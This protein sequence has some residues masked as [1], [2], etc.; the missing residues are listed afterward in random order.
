M[1]EA[2]SSWDACHQ[3]DSSLLVLTW[4]PGLRSCLSGVSPVESC[5]P[6]PMLSPLEGGHCAQPTLKPP[7]IP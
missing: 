6:L 7:L 1:R 4:V 3:H 2:V 5:H